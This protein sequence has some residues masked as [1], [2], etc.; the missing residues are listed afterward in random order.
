MPRPLKYAPFPCRMG[1]LTRL[2]LLGKS[3]PRTAILRMQEVYWS[4]RMR[5]GVSSSPS[6]VPGGSSEACGLFPKNIR[7]TRC[8]AGLFR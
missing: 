1:A 5:T 8:A 2:E 3:R 7:N 4:L 6:S